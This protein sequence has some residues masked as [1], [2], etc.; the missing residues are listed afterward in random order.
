MDPFATSADRPGRRAASSYGQ[1][2]ASPE[3][4][5]V[6]R[7]DPELDGILADPLGLHQKPHPTA[8]PASSSAS[9][10]LPPAENGSFATESLH[11]PRPTQSLNEYEPPQVGNLGV[12]DVFALIVNKMIG[13]GIYTN[14]AT[15]LTL[16]GSPEMAI[17]FWV[18]GVVYTIIR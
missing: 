2:S 9:P 11:E 18:V 14:P 3:S 1:S 5:Y 17:L 10:R 13:T 8:L 7:D 6:S 16:A 12:L 4:G 15:V